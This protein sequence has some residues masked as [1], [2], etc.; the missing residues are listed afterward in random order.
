MR[1]LFTLLLLFVLSINLQGQK[2]NKAAI[3]ENKQLFRDAFNEQLEMLQDKCPMSLKRAIWLYENAYCE[4]TLD[5]EKFCKTID[6]IVFKLRYTI[7][8]NNLEKYKTSGNWAVFMF[9]KDTNILNYNQPYG[10][11]FEDISGQK[12][13][14][15]MFVTKLLRTKKGNCSSLPLMYKILCDELGAK[16]F[17]AIAPRHLYVKHKDE[18][19]QWT[20]VELTNGTFPR[21]QWIIQQ[22]YISVEGIRS[23][24][25][26]NPL[27]DEE[28]IVLAMH[29]LASAYKSKYGIDTFVQQ[30]ANTALTYSPDNLQMLMLKS[31]CLLF[32][33]LVEEQKVLK[34]EEFR[35]S[36]FKAYKECIAKISDLGYTDMPAGQY[37]ELV[38]TMQ[39]EE[40]RQKMN[41]SR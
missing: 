32:F 3:E 25:Y 18:E 4:D 7:K 34:N 27:S 36:N 13:Y 12:D 28:N 15:K 39:E 38:N 35:K 41:K 22:L 16:A 11:D 17:L 40:E 2:A 20:N 1:R 24:V 9:M 26:M 29:Y 33:G 30:I 19:G 8:L 10:Y 31:D 5:Y 23:G 21:D 6:S 14:S 37:E